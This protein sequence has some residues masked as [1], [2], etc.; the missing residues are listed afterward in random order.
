MAPPDAV[1]AYLGEGGDP[2]ALAPE[3]F[4]RG[5]V[6]PTSSVVVTDIDGDA[7]LDLVA[8]ITGAT[9][10]QGLA[11][12]GS[13][14]LWRCQSGSYLRTEI[15][16]AQQDSP[17]PALREARDL[18]GDGVPEVVVAYP[19]CGAHTCFSQFAIF[20]WDGSVMVDRFQ[21]RSDDMP[22]PEIEFLADR[23]DLPA[24]IEITATGIASV[25]AGPYRVWS[26]RWNW[27]P[28]AGAFLPGEDVVEA[29]RY[30]IHVLHDADDAYLRGDLTTALELYRRAIEDDGL[31]DWPLPGD[32]RGEL[33]AYAAFRRVLALLAVG[34]VG[35][36]QVEVGSRL[37]A[38][39]ATTAAYAA[40]AHEVLAGYAGDVDQAC[41]AAA[42]IAAEHAETL[43]APLD[44][45]YA[46]RTYAVEDICPVGGG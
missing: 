2:A 28:A 11:D 22:S 26:R 31:L 15:A 4:E 40:L 19:V 37:A 14:Y 6:N 27:D 34:D 35:G 16:P 23:P 39:D 44:F 29:P 30:R 5:W 10:A 45:G 24:A 43:L 3:L 7:D 21:G 8:G 38:S 33:A 20:Q 25:G 1:S 42:S 12:S 46:N 13:V 41:A 32:R 36:A 9:G 18:T 17:F